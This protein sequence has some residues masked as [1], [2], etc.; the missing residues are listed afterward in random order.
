ME[1]QYHTLPETLKELSDIKFALDAS[2]IVAMT[3]P[4]GNIIYAND[5]FCEVSKYSR[6]ELIGQN[7]RIINSG[8]HPKEFF[9]DMW[10]TILQGQVWKG[11]IRNRAKD[12]SFYWVDTTIVPFLDD[13]ARPYQY[14][15]IRYEISQRKAMEDQ[16]KALPARI[17]QAQEQE[18]ERI[19]RDLHDD[20]G[21]SLATL[22]MLF[23]SAWL[24]KG[25][26]VSPLKEHKKILV[27]LDTII[28]KSRNLA[29]RLRPSTLEAL[30]LTTSINLMIDEINRGGQVKI[31]FTHGHL[32]NLHFQSETI[33][34]FRIVQEALTNIVKNAK[35]TNVRVTLRVIKNSLKITIEDNGCGFILKDKS[36]G[37]GLITMRERTSLLGGRIDIR[38]QLKKGTAI[39]ADIPCWREK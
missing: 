28:D 9:T 14:V 11:E 35:A 23:Q 16:I 22:K 30:G 12:G 5:K 2:A 13:K 27:Y 32:E 36:K 8:Y 33:N 24:Q 34:V 18:C 25:M 38:S 21:Q 19:A 3:D 37:L 39:I 17:I 26:N 1:V 31:V 20:L 15:S 29:M 6:A 4:A 10:S 7:H